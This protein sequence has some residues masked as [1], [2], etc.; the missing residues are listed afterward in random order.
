MQVRDGA[1]LAGLAETVAGE[2]SKDTEKE[3]PEREEKNQESVVFWKQR[4]Q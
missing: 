3:Q 1:G 4:M 2:V